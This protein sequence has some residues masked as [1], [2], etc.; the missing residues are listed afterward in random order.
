ML[1]GVCVIAP[2]GALQAQRL[3]H[4]P[5]GGQAAHRRPR[6]TAYL[7][8]RDWQGK[9]GGYAI[10]GRAAAFIPWINGSYSNVVGLPLAETVSR[11]VAR[12]RLP[13]WRVRHMSRELWVT[14]RRPGETVALARKSVERPVDLFVHRSGRGVTGNIY[15][16]RALQVDWHLAAAFVDIGLERRRGSCHWRTRIPPA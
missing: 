13:S 8:S 6:W 16:G 1:G 2:D 7:A 5:G 4:H 11:V 14:R 10:Q 3:V 12:P 15:V 9:A